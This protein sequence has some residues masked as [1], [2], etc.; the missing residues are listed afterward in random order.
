MT[1][2]KDREKAVEILRRCNTLDEA[3]TR[4]AQLTPIP[5]RSQRWGLF[6]AWD[7]RP[8]VWSGIVCDA[9]ANTDAGRKAIADYREAYEI[10]N[11]LKKDDL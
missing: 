2:L 3:E 5:N 4:L 9:S 11:R 6:D 1:F 10:G 7:G 8:Q